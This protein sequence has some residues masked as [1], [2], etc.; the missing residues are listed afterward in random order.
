MAV[1]FV[2]LSE[3]YR[4]C[5]RVSAGTFLA[6]VGLNVLSRF[7][8]AWRW[9]LIC[10][11]V[12]RLP[13]TS[14]LFLL[15]VNLLS[16]FAGIALPS[17]M[18]GE[19][20]RVMKVVPR[21]NAAA[22]TAASIVVDR[23]SG[24]VV[25]FFIALLLSPWLGIPMTGPYVVAGGAVLASAFVAGAFWLYRR[26]KQAQLAATVQTLDLA[27]RWWPGLAVLT[28]AGHLVFAGS[29]YLLF[30]EIDPLPLPTVVAVV[31]VAQLARTVPVSLLGIG[32]AEASLVAL[33]GLAGASHGAAVAVVAL[34]LVCR[35][36]FGISALLLE[37]GCDGRCFLDKL[38]QRSNERRQEACADG[39]SP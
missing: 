2:N 29:H 22:L 28:A 11:R 8:Y 39:E 37:L 21:T 15:R 32:V 13:G 25:M 6:Y 26:R 24:I 27:Y 19:A 20:V 14:P 12:F 33:A 10:T 18:G 38:A 34:S 31:M 35:Y 36:L 9:N 16:E 5:I 17:S 30:A 3:L 7:V 4:D 1:R 23:A